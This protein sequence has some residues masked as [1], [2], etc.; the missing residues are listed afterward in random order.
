MNKER[1]EEIFDLKRKASCGGNIFRQKV[2][3]DI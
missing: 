1:L 3:K 2:R